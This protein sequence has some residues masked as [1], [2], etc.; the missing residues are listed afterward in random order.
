MTYQNNF[1]ITTKL[2]FWVC[3]KINAVQRALQICGNFVVLLAYM[4]IKF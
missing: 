2:H 1:K 3:I 4:V